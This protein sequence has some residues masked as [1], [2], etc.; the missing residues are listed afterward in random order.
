STP[1]KWFRE[2]VRQEMRRVPLRRSR[3]ACKWEFVLRYYWLRM[4]RDCWCREAW[5][6]PQ[7]RDFLPTLLQRK[8]PGN[9]LN[10]VRF[11][12]D[13]ATENVLP[14]V[15]LSRQEGSWG[16]FSLRRKS[17]GCFHRSATAIPP[18]LPS[19]WISFTLNCTA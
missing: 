15:I 2:P 9:L 6:C 17:R 11:A 7:F 12:T 13:R 16:T 8:S 1:S 3:T 14:N 5:L 19:C 18:H 10:K 4:R